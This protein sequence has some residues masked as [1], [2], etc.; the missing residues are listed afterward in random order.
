MRSKTS[1]SSHSAQSSPQRSMESTGR[2][3][4]R[5]T[6]SIPLSGTPDSVKR[7]AAPTDLFSHVLYPAL[8]KLRTQ[9]NDQDTSDKPPEFMN[10][11]YEAF[12]NA[13][14]HDSQLL[15]SFLSD[16][17]DRL[18][19]YDHRFLILVHDLMHVFSQRSRTSQPPIIP[20]K[21]LDDQRSLMTS[22]DSD[23]LS[24]SMDRLTVTPP[25]IESN[26]SADMSDTAHYLFNRWKS[27]YL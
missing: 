8:N 24:L 27:R 23:P 6:R 9:L 7:K 20:S 12:E 18:S 16:I 5:S 13:D 1:A 10:Q 2:T 14:R 26:E 25:G 17:S 21:S 4:E 19:R 22:N 11:L 15:R 3:G